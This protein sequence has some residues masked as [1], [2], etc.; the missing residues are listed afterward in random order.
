MKKALLITSVI[1]VPLLALGYFY[2]KK[3]K[4]KITINKDGS[5]IVQLGDKSVNFSKGEG[6][7]IRTWNGWELSG[8]ASNYSLKHNGKGYASGSII[9]TTKGGDFVEIIHN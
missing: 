6:T 1:A 5:G 9:D 2:M 8:S 7:Q 4:G 3:P